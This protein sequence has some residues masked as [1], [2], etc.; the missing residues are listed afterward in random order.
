MN[1]LP[2]IPIP[3]SQVERDTELVRRCLRQCGR[4]LQERGEIPSDVSEAEINEVM[5]QHV[6]T[7]VKT[8]H[9]SPM[10]QHFTEKHPRQ[11]K[12]HIEELIEKALLAPSDDALA[13]AADQVSYWN[14]LTGQ[15]LSPTW[16]H[17]NCGGAV[18][19]SQTDAFACSSCKRT[20]SLGV[21]FPDSIT[22]RN[23][24]MFYLLKDVEE[25]DLV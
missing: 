14:P 3:L 13:V 10:Y 1:D 22:D 15:S 12:R 16:K 11:L 5:E 2:Y 7:I 17:R 8:L 24:Q 6:P 25:V 9:R 20:G 4:K 23:E 19:P 18:Y 21:S